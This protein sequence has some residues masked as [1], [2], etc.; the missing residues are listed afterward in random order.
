M[1]DKNKQFSSLKTDFDL[2]SCVNLESVYLGQLDNSRFGKWMPVSGNDLQK[3]L[4]NLL[5]NK[6]ALENQKPS[7]GYGIKWK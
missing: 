2:V 3:S 7:V 1:I 6:P 5:K 4:D